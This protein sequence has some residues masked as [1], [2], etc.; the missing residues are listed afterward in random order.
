MASE[1]D[2]EIR[3]DALGSLRAEH[4][5]FHF[6]QDLSRMPSDDEGRETPN[7]KPTTHPKKKRKHKGEGIERFFTKR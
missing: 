1:L 2:E 5:D 3:K 7:S 6:A 4:Q